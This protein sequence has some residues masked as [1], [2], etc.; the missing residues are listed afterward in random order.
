M[1][2]RSTQEIDELIANGRRLV[3]EAKAAIEKSDRFFAE[4]NIDP[5]KSLEFVREHAGEAAV[6]AIQ[7][8]VK[9]TIEGIE[10]D[11]RARRL[12]AAKERPAGKRVR[13]RP[14]II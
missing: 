14:N 11:L 2:S 8:Q 7:E 9:A 5:S 3:A 13:V 4:R 12:H 1:S 6:Q 10:Q